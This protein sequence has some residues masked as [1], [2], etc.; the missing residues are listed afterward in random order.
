MRKIQLSVFAA[1]LFLVF[2]AC[3]KSNN[4]SDAK[5]VQ[6]LSGSYNLT[7]AVLSANGFSFNVYDSLPVCEKDN[8][9]QLNA[10]GRYVTIDAGVVCDPKIEDAGTWTLSADTDSLYVSGGAATIIGTKG[11]LIKS[12]DGKTLVLTGIEAA[13]PP[14]VT[15]TATY[16]KK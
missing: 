14:Q 12:W 11:A 8:L 2:S 13:G 5:T 1:A 9:I 15:A 6:N 3:K 16:V 7:A 10:D 4:T